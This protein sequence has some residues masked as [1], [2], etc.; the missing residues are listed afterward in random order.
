[1]VLHLVGALAFVI[2]AVLTVL[3]VLSHYP[4]PHAVIQG[5][6]SIEHANW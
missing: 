6:Q 1:M 2:G 4:N 3:C 5:S